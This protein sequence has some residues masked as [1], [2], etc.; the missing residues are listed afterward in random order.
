MAR[1]TTILPNFELQHSQADE[2]AFADVGEKAVRMHGEG[3]PA[4]RHSFLP[5]RV[6]VDLERT[7]GVPAALADLFGPDRHSFS[8]PATRSPTCYLFSSA[9]S[10]EKNIVTLNR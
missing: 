1:I 2:P 9:Q 4:S 5:E 8:V 6:P 7:R 3:W 10:H